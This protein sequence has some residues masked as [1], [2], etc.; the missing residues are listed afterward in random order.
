MMAP[1]CPPALQELICRLLDKLAVAVTKAA[2][3]A[4]KQEPLGAAH[5]NSLFL[6]CFKVFAT[7]SALKGAFLTPSPIPANV[8]LL[9]SVV[10]M[11]LS[12]AL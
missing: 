3:N 12:P 5:A 8:I 11:I 2:R 9:A 10:A 1:V 6:F 4:A 7:T